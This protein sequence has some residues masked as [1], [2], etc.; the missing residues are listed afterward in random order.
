MFVN[1]DDFLGK[2][3]LHVVE[4]FLVDEDGTKQS[5]LYGRWTEFLCAAN[6]LG[7]DAHFGGEGSVRWDKVKTNGTGLPK[8]DPFELGLVPNSKL[9][10][11]VR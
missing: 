1:Q 9:L 7:V 10:W 2:S 5:F 11:K 6:L 3:S 8:H 4:G